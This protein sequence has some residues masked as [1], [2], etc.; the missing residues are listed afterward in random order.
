MGT[1]V[2]SVEGQWKLKTGVVRGDGSGTYGAMEVLEDDGSGYGVTGV[3]KGI[4]K[5][6]GGG[7]ID[8]RSWRAKAVLEG[9][10]KHRLRCMGWVG[11]ELT[12][13]PRARADG[14]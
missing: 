2:G 7:E 9:C 13:M 3:L 10:V 1:G 6:S 11:R 4:R 14:R 12:W 5:C 8:D